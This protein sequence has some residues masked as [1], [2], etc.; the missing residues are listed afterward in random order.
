MTTVSSA[1]PARPLSPHLQIYKPQISSAMSI[2]HRITGVGLALGL[3]VFVA[4][5]VALAGGNSSYA[6]FNKLIHTCIGQIMLL[7]WTWAFFY[8]FCCGIRHLLW[9]AGLFLNLKGM[10][11][12]GRIALGCSILFTIVV[13]FKA[14]GLLP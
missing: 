12:T 5:L 9:D 2:F 14:Y 8:H 13:W 6:V 4:W 7:G 10:H 1:K 3:P 11:T